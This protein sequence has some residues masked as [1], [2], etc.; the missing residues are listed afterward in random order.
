MLQN[1]S[2]AISYSEFRDIMMSTGNPLS[3][4]EFRRF[5]ALC[6]DESDGILR[7]DEFLKVLV[8]HPITWMPST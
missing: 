1:D 3:D 6:D 2:Q 5:F 8:A 4:V 7:L